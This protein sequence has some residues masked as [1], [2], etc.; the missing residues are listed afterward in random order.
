MDLKR[1]VILNTAIDSTHKKIFK[2]VT[3]A[4]HVRQHARTLWKMLE[5]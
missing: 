4:K 3:V 2:Y 5:F 1:T